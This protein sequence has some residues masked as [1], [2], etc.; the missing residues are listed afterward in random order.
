MM[1][2]DDILGFKIYRAF[3]LLKN[4][5]FH[6]F[7]KNEIAVN[8]EQWI[9]LNRLWDYDEQSQGD[10]LNLTTQSKGNFTRTLR[11]ME[12]ENLIIKKKNLKDNR[13]SIISLTP[14]SQQLKTPLRSIAFKELSIAIDGIDKAD[15]L[16]A[17]KVLTKIAENLQRGES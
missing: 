6:N 9:I 17:E 4:R 10:L 5:I 8:F 1:K 14:N 11:K 12:Q 7:Y 15:I 2:L 13:S 16:I 3:S